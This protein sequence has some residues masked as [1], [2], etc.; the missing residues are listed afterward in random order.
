PNP[1]SEVFNISW[2]SSS[3]EKVE[4]SVFDLTGKQLDRREVSPLEVTELQIGDR[5]PSGVYNVVIT[6]GDEVKTLKVV[7][8]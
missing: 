1:F 2:N 4:V 6:Q 3:D 7:K 5:Y 8:R